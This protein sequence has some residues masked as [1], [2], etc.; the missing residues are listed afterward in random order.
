MKQPTISKKA[1]LTTKQTVEEAFQTVL[2]TNLNHLVAWESVA[3]KGRDPNG[4]RKVRVSLRRMRSAMPIFRA[5]FPHSV[6]DP[7]AVELKWAQSQLGQARD[8]DV[9][10]HERLA[11]GGK[12]AGKTKLLQL[13]E[14][15]RD[16]AYLQVG[17]LLKGKRY[18]RFKGKFSKWISNK[19]WNDGLSRKGRKAV[20]RNIVPFAVA[21]LNKLERRVRKAGAKINSL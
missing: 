10:I 21:S 9:L 18:R 2:K 11:G 5:A 20:K 7:W 4:V 15:A 1:P 17:K 3:K 12:H 8:L 13:S 19:K 14:A 6:T 16:D